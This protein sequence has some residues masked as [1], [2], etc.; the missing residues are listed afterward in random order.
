MQDDRQQGES[1][2]QADRERPPV[3]QEDGQVTGGGRNRVVVLGAGY[4]GLTCFLELQAHLSGH[5]D[6]VL[7]N[8]DR[9][10]W[11]TTELHTYVAGEDEDQVRL[12][13]SRV[14]VRPGRLVVGQVERVDPIRRQVFLQGG[15]RLEYNLLVFAL[16]SE[17]EYYG[18][19]GAGQYSLTVGDWQQARELRSRIRRLLQTGSQDGGRAGVVVAGGGLT[20]VEVAGELV[21]EHPDRLHVTIL[22]A[23]PEIMPGFAPELVHAAREVF[24][25]KGVAVQ[26]A[27]P[28]VRVEEG[29]I[30]LK[31]GSQVP[32]DL[33]VWAGG[34]RGSS[35][36]AASGFAATKR[37]RGK[38]DAYLKAEGHPDVYVVGDSASF[39]DP[40]TGR[41][42]PPSGQAAVQM[43][44]A[45]GRN[46]VHRLHGQAEAPFVPRLRGAFASLG[47]REGVGQMGDEHFVGV[48]AMLVKHLIEARHIWE[49]GG[50]LMPLLQRLLKAP[51][52]VLRGRPARLPQ[53]VPASARPEVGRHA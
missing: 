16:G 30:L 40:A 44:R 14:V 41:E 23:G 43:G 50:G 10:H 25:A 5:N 46:I 51:R 49:T 52:R 32:Y 18:L 21:D 22:E 20:G 2:G 29:T 34:V 45:A 13:L 17:P 47:R 8:N 19:P 36:L 33:L 35:I 28:I 39:M 1:G 37:G 48:P 26:T 3:G 24:R 27:D 12:P 53:P 31:S 15:D 9:Y 4:A 42:L 7:V 38:V 6:L 11:F